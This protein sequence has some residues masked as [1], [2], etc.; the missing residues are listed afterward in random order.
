M[1]HIL[2][3][4]SVSQVIFRSAP[5]LPMPWKR[6]LKFF[7]FPLLLL[8]ILGGV[9]LYLFQ[10][11]FVFT[12][13]Y[14]A[15]KQDLYKKLESWVRTFEVD[16]EKLQ[17]WFINRPHTPLIVFFGGN[18]DDVSRTVKEFLTWTDYSYLTVNYRSFGYS[19]GSPSEEK[20]INDGKTIIESILKETGRTP[21]Q[22]ILIGES[23]GSGVAVGVAA[24]LPKIGKLLL[25]V[26]F[27]NL[28][29]VA[30]ERIPFYPISWMI[31]D[32]FSSD[33]RMKSLKCPVSIIS[34]QKDTVVPVT[35]AR[36]LAKSTPTLA[37]YTELPD[38]NH[39][40]L[41]ASPLFAPLFKK[42][43]SLPQKTTL[44]IHNKIQS[45]KT[46]KQPRP[47]YP[48]NKITTN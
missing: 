46:S 23:L 33:L 20:F 25:L 45:T 7:L 42:E 48:T 10:R 22:L 40:Q 8:Y 24:R 1:T 44:P 17:G 12:G 37:N 39:S 30:A 19:T 4:S 9:V 11:D 34:A 18:G 15:P 3:Y 43:A 5:A 36:R 26:P 27:D 38:I 29:S 2:S 13:R 47:Q 21:D 31:R 41:R 16:G 35:H 28:H 14:S 6:L 32:K